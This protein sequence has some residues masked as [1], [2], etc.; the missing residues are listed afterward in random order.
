MRTTATTNKAIEISS[1]HNQINLPA[2]HSCC[3]ISHHNMCNMF[4]NVFNKRIL[5]NSHTLLHFA[6]VADDAKCIVVT[7]VCVS[8]RGRMHTL[9]HGPG[10][11]RG[12]GRRCP[13][14][15]HYWADLQ[16][17]HGLRCYGNISRTRNVSKCMLVL[18]LWLV[19]II[20]ISAKED[21]VV[22]CLS[23]CLSVSNFAQKLL[24]GFAWNILERLVMGQ[25]TN[26]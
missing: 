20:I 23:A 8:V 10:C 7:Y 18:A 22:V 24:N 6:W 1:G 26:D 21:V 13:L 14:V 15:V 16:S 3:Q 9:L 12:S 19:A 2:R 17:V 4:D 11:N 5:L 25:W